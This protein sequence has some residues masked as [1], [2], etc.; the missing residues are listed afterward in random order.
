MSLNRGYTDGS[1]VYG[2]DGV[3]IGVIG[4]AG[5]TDINPAWIVVPYGVEFDIERN[6][7]DLKAIKTIIEGGEM[8][9]G[10]KLEGIVG[11]VH[12]TLT[13]MRQ[14]NRQLKAEIYR[15]NETIDELITRCIPK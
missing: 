6:A 15:K 4:P 1:R 5:L 2:P 8:P 11:L 13:T 10:F 14:Q 7:I 9:Q 12:H 3:S